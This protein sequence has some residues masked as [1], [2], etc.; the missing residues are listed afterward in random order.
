MERKHRAFIHRTGD[1]SD[2]TDI[3]YACE[4]SDA[5]DCGHLGWAEMLIAEFNEKFLR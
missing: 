5:T 2:W 4:I 1:R 3:D